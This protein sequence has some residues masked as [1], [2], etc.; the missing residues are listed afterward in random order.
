MQPGILRLKSDGKSGN[1][2]LPAAVT[3]FLTAFDAGAYP[4]LELRK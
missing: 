4:D 2:P 1:F 3:S